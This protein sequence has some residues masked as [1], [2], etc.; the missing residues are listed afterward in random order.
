MSEHA[1][2]EHPEPRIPDSGNGL[3]ADDDAATEP[4]V[5]IIGAGRAGTAFARTMIRAGIPVDICSTRPPRALRHHLKIYA[6]GANPVP[7]EEITSRVPRESGIIVLA[8]P[9]E[10]LDDVDPAWIGPRILIDATNTWEDELLPGW[11]AGAIAEQLPSSM[12]IAGRFRPARVVK[13]LNHMGHHDLED[14]ASDLP[15]RQRRALALAGD[16]DDARGRVMGLI[17][18]MGFDPVSLGPLAAGS[19]MEPGAPLFDTRLTRAD[20]LR[21]AR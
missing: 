5:G 18:R 21:Y 6:P 8:V 17:V 12:A 3:P 15:L 9:Q 2:E 20:I 19:V 11:L 4:A 1:Y 13:A 7:A 16:D 14:A 10:D